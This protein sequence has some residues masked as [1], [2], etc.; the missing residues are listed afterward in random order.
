MAYTDAVKLLG[1]DSGAVAWLGRLAGVAAGTI[2]AAS[3]GTV[4]FFALRDEAVRWGHGAVRAWQE[5]VRGLGRY[6]R[7]ER[8]TAAHTVLVVTS[9]FEAFDD[10]LASQ[11]LD[12]TSAELTAA[13]QVALGSGGPLAGSYAEMVGALMAGEAPGPTPSV[14][15]ETLASELE[16]YYGTR[17]RTVVRFLN[18]LAAFPSLAGAGPGL[19]RAAVE[20]Y[21]ESYRRLALEIPEFRLW[22]EMVD[23][24]STRELIRTAIEALHAP[25]AVLDGVRAGLAR[26]YRAQLNS[27]VLRAADRPEGLTLPTL[28]QGYREPAGLVGIAFGAS[29][30]A[31]ET[32]WGSHGRLVADVQDF[33]L[34]HLTTVAA[35]DGPVVVLGQPGS[36]KS[37]LTQVLAARLGT[38]DF[39]PVRV[40]LRGVRA[41]APVQ[42]QIEEA[43][44]GLLGERI[45]WPA[46]AGRAGTA[47]PV[48]MMDGF[49][50][51]LQATGQNWADYLEQLQEFQRREAELGRPLAVL[52]TSRLV[53]ADRVRLPA[54]TP[55]VRLEPFDDAQ[56]TG[57]LDVWNTVNAGNLAARRLRPLTPAAVIEHRD[58]AGQP[59]L[60]LLLA[61]YD[62]RANRLQR[63]GGLGRTELY[64]RL[65]ADFF[66]RQVDKFG[67]RITTAQRDEEV[68]AEW[69]RLSA[70]AVA[71]H[72]RGR[73]V[74]LEVELDE[75]LRHLLSEADWTPEPDRRAL[76]AGQLLVGRFFFIHESQAS[77]NTGP[78]ERSFEFLHAT[79]G[80]FLAARQIV[81]A[82]VEL[83]EDRAALRRRPGATLDAGYFYALTS[84][85]TV[86]RRAPL[87]EFCQAVVARLDPAIR[88]RCLDLVLELLPEAG[89][90]ASTW[91]LSG[92]VPARLTAAERQ[93]AFSANLMCLAVA[94]NDGP[95]DAVRLVGEPVVINWR[96]AALLWMSQLVPGD[97]RRL[98]Q[99]FR[100]DWD[101]ESG[102]ARLRVRV[103][104]GAP[105]PV[106]GSLPW[107]P[108]DRPGLPPENDVEI[109]SES[110]TGGTLRKSAFVQTGFDSREFLYV[111]MPLWERFGDIRYEEA[112]KDVSDARVLL[113][114]LTEGMD[115]GYWLSSLLSINPGMYDFYMQ[116][117]RRFASPR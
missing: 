42:T 23:S 74:I 114:L 26:R 111:L 8:L 70:V 97:A 85:A 57:W 83:A 61:L 94:L 32:W 115:A 64:E 78:A 67:G 44:F 33:L 79:F 76:T 17:A 106:L 13:E 95:I 112:H 109:P 20:R 98:W 62:G 73:E 68:A 6:N 40:E 38:A 56:I 66:E 3:V 37:V 100:V 92:Y 107:P 12:L 30:I 43:V 90:P 75:D 102:P 34:A 51:L 4:D 58:L 89:H 39:L 88:A 59:L 71:M 36:G 91:T 1:G 14:P 19:A 27:P 86:T 28:G 104:D 96:R 41:D 80:E 22:S 116:L 60:L 81:A 53:V 46:L 25:D 65:F 54:F 5:N 55:V 24:S 87:W 45:G 10:W 7:T 105:V 52:V 82:L 29:L 113:G 50:E 35:T 11:G 2:T 31:T 47:L 18:G 15:F 21:A 48:V 108:E 69:R 101:F 49:D 77:R 16:T 110:A 93:A 99:S 84:F 117:L 72:N 9:F 63:G 103:E